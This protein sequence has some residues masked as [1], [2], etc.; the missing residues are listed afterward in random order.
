L[1]CFWFDF[2]WFDFGDLSPMM[3]NFLILRLTALRNEKFLR[4][5]RYHA[6]CG[7]ECK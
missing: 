3:F 7:I 2:F 4:R 5:Q 1:D 6:F